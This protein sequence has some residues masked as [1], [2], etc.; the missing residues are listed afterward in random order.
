MLRK[1]KLQILAAWY[2]WC[3]GPVPG[4]SPAVEKHCPRRQKCSFSVAGNKLKGY[5]IQQ[6]KVPKCWFYNSAS[7]TGR[8]VSLLQIRI[9]CQPCQIILLAVYTTS[10]SSTK[11]CK[12]THIVCF[13]V[14]TNLTTKE[15]LFL[16][17][18]L[19]TCLC[20]GDAVCLLW[21]VN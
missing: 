18:S 4:H 17:A 2:N 6:E 12:L 8:E 19:I 5:I 14:S 1:L 3:Q 10:L 11:L 7:V 15:W 21:G 16:C 20:K 9:Y 13:F